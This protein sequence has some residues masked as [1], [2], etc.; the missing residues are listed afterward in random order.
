MM[1]RE[2]FENVLQ[3]YLAEKRK[4]LRGNSFANI[5]RRDLPNAIREK[6]YITNKYKI[7]GSPGGGNWAE[8][9]WVAV[10]DLE[11]TD[12]PGREFFI[13]YLFD[14]E[15]NGVHLSLNQG[16]TQYEE[17]FGNNQRAARQA[18]MK[19]TAEYQQALNSSFDFS[20]EPIDFHATHNLGKGYRHGHIC[21]KFYAKGAIP[22][23]EVLLDDLRNL[24]GVYR[25]LK[26]AV[27][28]IDSGALKPDATNFD[29]VDLSYS[30]SPAVT[31]Q[32][33]VLRPM[34]AREKRENLKNRKMIFNEERQLEKNKWNKKVGD[35]AEKF[36]RDAEI[37]RLTKAG[38]K[39]LADDVQIVSEDM[40]LG[41][42]V[43]SFEEDGTEK[44][45]EV[46]GSTTDVMGFILT[47][48]ELE[49]SKKLKNYYLYVVRSVGKKN[50]SLSFVKHP[51]FESELFLMEPR[52][53]LVKYTS[54]QT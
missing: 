23:D 39:K 17:K 10:L 42:D 35:W 21:G 50:A 29:D 20:T 27:K 41:Y 19:K 36:V 51:T 2:L 13:A 34:P 8:I 22:S 18:M 15:M 9:P 6:A 43:L 31:I 11:I 44:Y 37:F 54:V 33:M 4:P 12:T 1:I 7:K 53:Y 26:G 32:E 47:A 40:A 14:A 5:L 46:K 30:F 38:K 28:A 48:H 3:N 52:S 25:E 49:K 16:W 45:I 24:L